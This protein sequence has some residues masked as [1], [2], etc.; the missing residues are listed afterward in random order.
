VFR[1]S[2]ESAATDSR[3]RKDSKNH[4]SAD[5][6]VNNGDRSMYG[7]GGSDGESGSGGGGADQSLKEYNRWGGEE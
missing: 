3:S 4:G 2:F 1:S 6:E 5:S 7:S